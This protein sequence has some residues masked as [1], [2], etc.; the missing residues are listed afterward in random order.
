MTTTR[1]RR[2]ATVGAALLL[3]SLT[4]AGCS[5]SDNTSSTTP[6]PTTTTSAAASPTATPQVCID[7]EVTKASLQSIVSVNVLKDGTNALRS[8]FAAFKSDADTLI[9]SAQSEF[10]TQTTAVKDSIAQFQTAMDALKDKPSVAEVAALA[11]ALASIKTS[12]QALLD[13][14]QQAC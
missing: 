13:A 11:P 5:N 12:T 14:V 4:L 3:G 7:A 10:S 1:T 6:S 9:A 2:L 8:N